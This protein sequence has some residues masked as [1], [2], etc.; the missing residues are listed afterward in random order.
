MRRSHLLHAVPAAVLLLFAFCGCANTERT[1][2]VND[3]TPYTSSHVQKLKREADAGN[4]MAANQLSGYYGYIKQ[5]PVAQ[6][7]WLERAAALRYP[8]AVKSLGDMLLESSNVKDR[9]RGR[10]L[11]RTLS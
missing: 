5:D 11:L 3:A 6:R 4:G 9:Q 10:R 8:P 2:A 1:V 7:R